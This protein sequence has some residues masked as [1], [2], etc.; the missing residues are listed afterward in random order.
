M[1]LMNFVVR[2][3]VVFVVVVFEDVVYFPAMVLTSSKVS[4]NMKM[5][6]MMAI[7]PR[8][9]QK[10]ENIFTKRLSLLEIIRTTYFHLGCETETKSIVNDN[11]VAMCLNL[12]SY[13]FNILLYSYL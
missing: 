6:V 1:F 12:K 2:L 5:P 9:W 7:E 3:L 8:A 13:F 10:Q 4:M 11:I